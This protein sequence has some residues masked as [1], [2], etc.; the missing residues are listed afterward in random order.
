MTEPRRAAERVE[1]ADVVVADNPAQSRYEARLGERVVG[2][3]EY[4]IADDAGPITFTH[5]E[6]VPEAEGLGIGSRLARAALDDVRARG[7]RL[8]SDCPF[9]SAYLKRHPA[10]AD[11]VIAA[12]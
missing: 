7:L 10:D 12:D 3:V 9:I 4:E 6:V 8:I 1:T 2:V 11:L 5:T